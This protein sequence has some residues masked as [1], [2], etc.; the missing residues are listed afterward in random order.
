MFFKKKASAPSLPSIRILSGEKVLYEG[1][2]KDVPIKEDT[3]IGK[4]IYFFDDPDPCF[5]HRN[6]VRIRLTEE[7]HQELL[8]RE[9]STPGPL[10]LAYADVAEM[11][12]CLLL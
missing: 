9:D 2:L 4:S 10:L 8:A 1:L 12:Q 3:I 6:A 7:L 11:D 5:I